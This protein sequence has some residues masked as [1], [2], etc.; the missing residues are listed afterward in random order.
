MGAPY[1][2]SIVKFDALDLAVE[3]LPIA[4]VLSE[5]LIDRVVSLSIEL[6]IGIHQHGSDL[7][8]VL[9]QIGRVSWVLANIHH[10]S[11]GLGHI[12]SDLLLSLLNA[13]VLSSLLAQSGGDRCS[14]KVPL[15]VL[16]GFRVHTKVLSSI[17]NAVN[18][19]V[20][21]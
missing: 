18:I 15:N 6:I 14:I 1:L 16:E 2:Y 7:F 4:N 10:A 11:D 9:V 19:I 20:V 5:L 12:I 17:L 3:C 8:L 13:H 21:Y